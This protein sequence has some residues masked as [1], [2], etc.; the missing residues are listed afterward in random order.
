MAESER[1]LGEEINLGSNYEIS[2]GDTVRLIA[3]VMNAE[4]EVVTDGQRLRPEKSEVE[5]LWADNS[6]ARELLGWSP[7]YGGI[8]GFRRALRETVEWF[9]E[10]DNLRQYKHGIYNT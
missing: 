6:K 7:S 2:I 10:P 4:V 1:A 5:R 3:E 9:A 8:D